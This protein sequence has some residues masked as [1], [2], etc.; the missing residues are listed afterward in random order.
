M[1]TDA[2]PLN[3]QWF[4]I[5]GVRV[6][7][8][9]RD[10]SVSSWGYAQEF[11]LGYEAF[12]V[13]ERE[14]D[15]LPRDYAQEWPLPDENNT[16]PDKNKGVLAYQD[17]GVNGEV[18]SKQVYDEQVRDAERDERAA[19]EAMGEVKE[20]AETSTM[21]GRSD[22]NRYSW[23]VTVTEPD[24]Y[25]FRYE[26]VIYW[27]NDDGETIQME[28]VKGKTLEGLRQAIEAKIKFYMNWAN[29]MEEGY[30]WEMPAIIDP[31]I[32][33][34]ENVVDRGI[35]PEDVPERT[36]EEQAAAEAAVAETKLAAMN[37]HREESGTTWTGFFGGGK[38]ATEAAE[39]TD[40]GIIS[41]PDT[42]MDEEESPEVEREKDEAQLSFEHLGY[43]IL[44]LLGVMLIVFVMK[45]S[46]GDGDD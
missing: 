17:W 38:T 3:S 6:V 4:P 24:E 32:L 46:G 36:P 39:Q 23:E 30:T 22:P 15:P 7:R 43:V 16:R 9:R 27:L 26:A 31:G 29:M 13:I 37:R 5:T 14:E 33:E 12:T 8:G 21:E 45:R 44:A 34:W 41:G 2:V 18:P 35:D 42:F 25:G 40:F 19:L 1:D 28:T 20:E 11:V 10:V